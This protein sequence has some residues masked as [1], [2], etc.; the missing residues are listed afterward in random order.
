MLSPHHALWALLYVKGASS[1][2]G[3]QAL[4][5]H[6]SVADHGDWQSSL[7]GQQ[8]SHHGGGDKARSGIVWLA[9]GRCQGNG[10]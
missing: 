6:G 5:L 10:D 9:V 2:S 4:A 7:W 8:Q 1:Q 3:S